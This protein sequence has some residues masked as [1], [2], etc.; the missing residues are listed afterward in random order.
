M[1]AYNQRPKI[2]SSQK[3]LVFLAKAHNG[4]PG[5]SAYPLHYY[6]I[7]MVKS[8]FP[9]IQKVLVFLTMA[10]NGFPE[11]SLP[12]ALLLYKRHFSIYCWYQVNIIPT[13]GVGHCSKPYLEFR[14]T[15]ALE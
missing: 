15:E 8:T 1:I 11:I 6:Y 2:K 10:H 9:L 14:N 5:K 12:V 3:V 4:F 13:H 7:N